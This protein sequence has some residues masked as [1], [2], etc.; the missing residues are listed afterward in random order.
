MKSLK[1]KHT[2]KG[3]NES[4]E[5]L[6]F[7]LNTKEMKE[8]GFEGSFNDLAD[9][10][11]KLGAQVSGS[12]NDDNDVIMTVYDISTEDLSNTLHDYGISDTHPFVDE[13]GDET[14]NFDEY[15]QSDTSEEPENKDNHSRYFTEND[16]LDSDGSEE[17]N[18]ETSSEDK[19]DIDELLTIKANKPVGPVNEP[20]DGSDNSDASTGIDISPAEDTEEDNNIDKQLLELDELIKSIHDDGSEDEYDEQPEDGSE[21]DNGNDSSIDDILN[22]DGSENDDENVNAD[23]VFDDVNLLEK[24]KAVI[25]EGTKGLSESTLH[26]ILSE[27]KDQYL[28][29]RINHKMSAKL[30]L[31]ENV[32]ALKD[33]KSLNEKLAVKDAQHKQTLAEEL[34]YGNVIKHTPY[35]KVRV[36]GKKLF[37]YDYF[38]I[39]SLLNEAKKVFTN[40][41]KKYKLLNESVKHSKTSKKNLFILKKQK[42]LIAILESQKKAM[43]HI[44]DKLNESQELSNDEANLTSIIFKV[45]DADDFIKTLTDNGIPADVLEKKDTDEDGSDGSAVPDASTAQQPADTGQLGVQPTMQP[46]QPGMAPGAAP[47]APQA[48]N[49]FE[50]VKHDFKLPL[51]EE[52]NPFADNTEQPAPTDPA[53]PN[54]DISQQDSQDDTDEGEE[55]VL[56]D[57][58]YAKKV[59][60]I[61]RDVYKYPEEEFNNKIGGEIESDG[62]ENDD[63]NN[64]KNEGEDSGKNDNADDDNDEQDGTED[65]INPE[66]VFGNI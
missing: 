28:L 10:L 20:E 18:E 54:N 6:V 45:K 57:T 27:V 50:S 61:L 60:E 4:A 48:N 59:E 16:F 36:N 66:D 41:F 25:P 38:G 15:S 53:M 11:D 8:A 55:V 51:N 64:E 24:H 12:Y 35:P 29:E 33:F 58:S 43:A 30:N 56:T 49:P 52:D 44:Q 37:E 26:A 9:D 19:P 1:N 40:N 21:E 34:N 65:H 22:N 23:D 17:D 46:A 13:E 3:L 7:I 2:K 32:K 63:M 14:F 47:A 42:N 62:S 39:C 5:D 31:M